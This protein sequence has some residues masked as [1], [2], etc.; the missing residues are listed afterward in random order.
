M[1]KNLLCLLLVITSKICH[2]QIE[3]PYFKILSDSIYQANKVKQI[4]IFYESNK[5]CFNGVR[6]NGCIW[7]IGKFDEHGQLI[8]HSDFSSMPNSKINHLYNK[9]LKLEKTVSKNLLTKGLEYQVDTSEYIK[10]Y[11]YDSM[12]RLKSY[13]FGNTLYDVN[14]PK[15]NEK[16]I[17]AYD[18]NKFLL[19]KK[20]YRFYN[21][22][23]VEINRKIYHMDTSNNITDTT[24]TN[25]SYNKKG[26]LCKLSR[27]SSGF[28]MFTF[29]YTYNKNGLI[30]EILIKAYKRA[31]LKF[32]YL[33][34]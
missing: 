32:E 29:K 33:Y 18:S 27:K 8:E 15:L 3:D 2:S 6:Q 7:E 26:Q 28:F 10:T 1:T 21:D 9:E 14:Y 5:G 17:Y 30:S 11:E 20:E 19:N 16:I 34:Y 13:H 23:E 12:E 22:K 31:K 4:V 25:Y 24:V